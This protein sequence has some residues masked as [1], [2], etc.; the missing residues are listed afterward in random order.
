MTDTLDALPAT[1]AAER[2][3]LQRHFG[4]FD[5][6][7]F[8]ICTIVGVDT[9]ATVA[10]GGGQA[11]TWMMAFA[12]VFFVPQALLFAELGSAFPQEGGR[13]SGCRRPAPWPG[14]SSSACSRCR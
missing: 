6:L 8:L 3:K 1:A 4:R 10:Q 12:V 7:F 2:Q 11:F 5:I 13:P 9:I 14:S